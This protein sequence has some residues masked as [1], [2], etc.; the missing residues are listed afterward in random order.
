MF[1]IFGVLSS[2]SLLLTVLE[3]FHFDRETLSKEIEAAKTRKQEG[4]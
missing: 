1:V 4:E 3:A 2:G